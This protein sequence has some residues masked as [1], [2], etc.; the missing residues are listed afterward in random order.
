MT[1]PYETAVLD[2]QGLSGWVDGDRKITAM[3]KELN[4]TGSEIVISA[5]TIVEVTHERIRLP[6]LEWALSRM[7]IEPVTE[8][9][10]KAAAQLLKKVRL[11]GHKH[12]I[13]S[14]VAEVAL[15]Q[16]GPVALLTS[17][18]DDMRRLCEGRVHIVPL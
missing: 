6:R 7:K 12:A 13:D 1:R 14:T 5:N 15:R 2:S 3:L 9:A 16:P 11:H 8:R 10:A 18:P 17:D 4:D